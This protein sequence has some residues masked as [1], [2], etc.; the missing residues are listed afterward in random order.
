MGIKRYIVEVNQA[1]NVYDLREVLNKCGAKIKDPHLRDAMFARLEILTEWAVHSLDV[2][3]LED[4]KEDIEIATGHKY[5][6][7]LKNIHKIEFD[8]EHADDLL[9]EFDASSEKDL[10][11][12]VEKQLVF[13][14]LRDNDDNRTKAAECLGISIRT[15]RNKLNLYMG[16]TGGSTVDEYGKQSPFYKEQLSAQAQ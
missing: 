2:L 16:R 4:L 14:A 7:H 13:R 3:S 10:W 6:T 9:G 15:L 11:A 12:R 1:C 8:I 5:A